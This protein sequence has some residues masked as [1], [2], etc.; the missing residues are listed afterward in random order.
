MSVQELTDTTTALHRLAVDQ[1]Q[2]IRHWHDDAWICCYRTHITINGQFIV[3]LA[4]LAD[5]FY[6]LATQPVLP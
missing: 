6:S 5:T 3:C 4:Q 1:P 2:T